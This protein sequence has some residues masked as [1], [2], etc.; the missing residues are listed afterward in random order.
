MMKPFRGEAEPAREREA[1]APTIRLEIFRHDEKAT[2][3]TAGPRI[4][5]E[6]V[7][8]TPKGRE[9]ATEAGKGQLPRP[10]VAVA[11][12][13][14]RER[15]IETAFRHMLAEQAD[16][17]A[18]MSLEEIR[19]EVAKHVKVGRKDVMTE[20]L[21]FNWDGTKE[22]HDRAYERY[23]KSKDAL[24]FLVEDSDAVAKEF[25][26]LISTTY[27]RSA[28]GVAEL[29]QRYFAILPRWEKIAKKDPAK[30]QRFN[31]ELQRFLGSHQ[32]VTECFLMK[33]IEKTKGRDAVQQFIASLP[34]KNG[35]GLSEG[36]TIIIRA[37]GNVSAAVVRFKNEEWTVTPE[38][39][40][41]I[42]HDRDALHEEIAGSGTTQL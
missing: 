40:D 21:N 11:Y 16:I 29:V 14:T 3:T 4:G 33:V 15:A 18:D 2:P 20:R 32:T 25:H 22:F 24:T 19:A 1:P 9:H 13:S 26:D 31:N 8:L 37:E 5:D 28:A 41:E 7:R 30:Y 42:I 34:D 39:L 38:V 36:F 27:S 10:E 6:F 12:G 17:T 23:L 35:F